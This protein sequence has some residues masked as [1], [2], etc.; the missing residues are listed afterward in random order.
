MGDYSN[1]MFGQTNIVHN[2]QIGISIGK[3]LATQF[4]FLLNIFC[5]RTIR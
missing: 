5:F 4:Y 1:Q 3:Y 2:A